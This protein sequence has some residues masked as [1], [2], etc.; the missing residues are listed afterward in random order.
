MDDV[1]VARNGAGM[2]AGQKVQLD[3]VTVGRGPRSLPT[4]QV[5]DQATVD[6]ETWYTVWVYNGE[7]IR[8]I[9][10]QNPAQW[11]VHWEAGRGLGVTKF[12]IHEQLM[13]LMRLKWD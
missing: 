2:I 8:W 13:T 12:D 4:C 7:V 9:Q 5:L 10:E 3:R 6:G 1:E 11:V